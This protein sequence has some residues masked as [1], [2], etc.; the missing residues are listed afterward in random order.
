VVTRDRNEPNHYVI[1]VE[2]DSYEAAMENSNRADTQELASKMQ[3]LVT[4]ITFQDLDVI[5]DLGD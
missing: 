3:A 5:E 1:V 4:S 2:F